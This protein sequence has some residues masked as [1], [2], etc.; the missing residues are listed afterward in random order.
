MIPLL[1]PVIFRETVPLNVL[2]QE[3]INVS[4]IYV[5]HFPREFANSMAI[6]IVMATAIKFTQWQHIQNFNIRN[7]IHG[8]LTVGM[9]SSVVDRFEA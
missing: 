6:A 5:R 2:G 3:N 1:T 4:E 7:Y 9:G 8:S